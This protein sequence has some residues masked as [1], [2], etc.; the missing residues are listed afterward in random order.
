M[1][2]R[3]LTQD[4]STRANHSSH[5]FH[6]LIRLKEK[7]GLHLSY[8]YDLPV[9]YKVWPLTGK[10]M[11]R[12]TRSLWYVSLNARLSPRLPGARLR[13]SSWMSVSEARDLVMCCGLLPDE[14]SRI[15]PRY[16]ADTAFIW[17]E[18][19]GSIWMKNMNR[20]YYRGPQKKKDAWIGGK[21]WGMK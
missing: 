20:C 8:H 2:K 1:S 5:W 6:I 4:D 11:V 14:G 16:S 17:A 10:L 18:R 9:T 19:R 3:N 7:S 21:N 12:D 15:G 13:P